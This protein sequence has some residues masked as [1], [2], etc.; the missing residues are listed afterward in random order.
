MADAVQLE[1]QINAHPWA[2]V[3]A[4]VVTKVTVVGAKA[5]VGAIIRPMIA[6]RVTS[7]VATPPQC[8][9]PVPVSTTP[10][11]TVVAS[12]VSTVPDLFDGAVL[13]LLGFRNKER[14]GIQRQGKSR[15]ENCGH[16]DR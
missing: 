4:R 3:I 16:K 8:E 11:V 2:T 13:H 5:V 12:P 14:R 7:I 10:P 6:A 15:T 9:P 1:F